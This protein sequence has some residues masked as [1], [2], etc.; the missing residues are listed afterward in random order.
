MNYGYQRPQET[1]GGEHAWQAYRFRVVVNE[2]P[3]KI[4]VGSTREDDASKIVCSGASY[5]RMATA[6]GL[7]S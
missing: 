1:V 2:Q 5:L 6:W 4:I 7:G 3:Y